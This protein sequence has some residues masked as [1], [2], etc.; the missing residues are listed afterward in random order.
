MATDI[1]KCQLCSDNSS[2]QAHSSPVLISVYTSQYG[3][4]FFLKTVQTAA[5]NYWENRGELFSMTMQ[6]STGNEKPQLR[7]GGGDTQAEF[8]HV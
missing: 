7:R 3:G 6:I 5:A 2:F 1:R 4:A 8:S